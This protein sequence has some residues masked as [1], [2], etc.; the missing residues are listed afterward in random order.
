[1]AEDEDEDGAPKSR[2]GRLA[3]YPTCQ[4]LFE[5]SSDLT[6]SAHAQKENFFLFVQNIAAMQTRQ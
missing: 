4:E 2:M 5:S 1:M 3:L 6:F